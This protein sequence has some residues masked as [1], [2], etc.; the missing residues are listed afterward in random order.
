MQSGAN[1]G[2]VSG[3]TLSSQ[4]DATAATTATL[5]IRLLGLARRANNAFGAYATWLVKI[6]VHELGTGTGAAGV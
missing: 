1:N 5:P 6:N 4:T 2:Y 3:W